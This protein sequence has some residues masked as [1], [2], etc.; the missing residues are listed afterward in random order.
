MIPVYFWC[1]GQDDN[2]GDIVLRR[3]LLRALTT[4]ETK[5]NVYSGRASDG[6]LE[7]MEFS[8]QSIYTARWRW[9]LSLC[10]SALF[11]PTVL[12]HN[13]GEIRLDLKTIQAQTALLL[14]QLLIRLRGGQ[15]FRV[16]CAVAD[17]ST[18]TAMLAALL[19]R[20]SGHLTTVSRWRDTE[21]SRK[22]GNFPVSPD[23]AF[24]E[25][26]SESRFGDVRDSL[27]VTF[28]SDRPSPSDDVLREI[29][30][31]AEEHKLQLKAVV[32]VRRDRQLMTSIS[33]RFDMELVDWPESRSHIQQEK[34]V[35]EEYRRS[36]LVISDRI[37]A[38]IIGATEGALPASV[39]AYPDQKVGRHFRPVG[40]SEIV[41]SQLE[42]P[43]Y[44]LSEFLVDILDRERE[45]CKALKAANGDVR[46]VDLLLASAISSTR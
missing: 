29:R 28:R 4:T 45:I 5:V 12:V 31:F 17:S 27:T 18:R 14:P 26:G 46:D 21:S 16:G 42:A 33:Q 37:H 15:N 30:T 36:R 32:Q 34:M 13:A 25:M 22:F 3:R 8:T 41:W 7:A 1:T 44:S 24:G 23:L 2:L 6:F 43:P 35:R 11:K 38:L 39:L 19:V 9:M 20:I 10:W 40:I